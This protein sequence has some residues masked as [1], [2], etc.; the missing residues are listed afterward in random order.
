MANARPSNN[1]EAVLLFFSPQLKII[2]LS[3]KKFSCIS[4]QSLASHRLRMWHDFFNQS[5]STVKQSQSTPGLLSAL[6]WK[7]L[8]KDHNH[9]ATDLSICRTAGSRARSSAVSPEQSVMVLSKSF[10]RNRISTHSSW[11][12]AE[13]R[14]RARNTQKI[15]LNPLHPRI[16]MHILHTVLYTFSKVLTRRI[17]LTNNNFNL[18]RMR[19][20][21]D[22]FP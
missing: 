7:N 16:S 2:T 3:L 13:L 21:L 14:W 22:R 18:K 5:Q 15:T 20:N 12:A 6:S 19:M 9:S 8:S 4:P 1:W 17:C 10:T 11:P